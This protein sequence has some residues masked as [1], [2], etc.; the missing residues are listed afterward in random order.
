MTLYAVEV[1]VP[2]E[3]VDRDTLD[4]Y[5]DAVMDALDEESARAGSTVFDCDVSVYAPVT[6]EPS[7][8]LT[9]HTFTHADSEEQ[10]L[11]NGIRL[12]NHV[13]P[14]NVPEFDATLGFELFVQEFDE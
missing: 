8:K 3:G 1:T 14:Q 6:D 12:A 13:V 2:V 5:M 7:G 10:A 9:V 4:E 11:I